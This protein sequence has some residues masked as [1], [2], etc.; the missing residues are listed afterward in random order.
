MVRLQMKK[1][2]VKEDKPEMKKVLRRA[3][4]RDIDIMVTE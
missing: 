2:N 1:R 4:D 3:T